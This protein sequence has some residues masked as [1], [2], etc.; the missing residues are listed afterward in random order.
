M[1]IEESSR[2]SPEVSNTEVSDRRRIDGKVDRKKEGPREF[3]RKNV[4]I[5]VA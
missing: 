2:L 4:R 1:K 5:N 3:R